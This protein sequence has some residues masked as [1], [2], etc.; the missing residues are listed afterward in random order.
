MK[1]DL[2]FQPSNRRSTRTSRT[3][4]RGRAVLVALLGLAS[5]P[6]S[7]DLVS[8]VRAKEPAEPVVAVD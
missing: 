3:R 4:N 5:I 7:L 1:F 2:S 6:M 8:V